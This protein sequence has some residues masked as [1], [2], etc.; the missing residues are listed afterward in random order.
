M[1]RLVPQQALWCNFYKQWGNHSM[2]N[3]FNRIQH[4]RE[5]ALGNA[6]QAQIDGDTTIPILDRQPPLPKIAP[7]QIVNHKKVYNDERALVP[8]LPYKEDY[9][10]Y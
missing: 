5:K 7:L 1:V 2:E 10:D 6:P 3:C 8:I 9:G 4:M